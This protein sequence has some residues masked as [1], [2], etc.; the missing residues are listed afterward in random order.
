MDPAARTGVLCFSCADRSTLRLGRTGRVSFGWLHH[1]SLRDATVVSAPIRPLLSK[2][3]CRGRRF[4]GLPTLKET[5][6]S[7]PARSGIG[8]ALFVR[9]DDGAHRL[10]RRSVLYTNCL[11]QYPLKS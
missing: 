2:F 11:R 5:W 4:S 8:A 9:A 6:I 10:P 3:S 1:R 7:R